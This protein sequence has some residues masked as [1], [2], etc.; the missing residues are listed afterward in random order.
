MRADLGARIEQGSRSAELLHE[1]LC[2]SDPGRIMNM[3]YAA[4]LS[5]GKSVISIAELSPGDKITARLSD[6]SANLTVENI[7]PEP[8]K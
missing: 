1:R 6:G 7:L 2:A 5:G 4:L 3:G 8:R